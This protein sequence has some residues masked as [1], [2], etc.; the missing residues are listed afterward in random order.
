MSL[1]LAQLQAFKAVINAEPTLV[2][3]RGAGN[4]G[5]IAAFYNGNA[6]SGTIWRPAITAKE[7]NTAIVWAEFIL[8]TAVVQN[9]YFALLQAGVI[10]ATSSNVRAGFSTIFVAAPTSLANL[11]AL[12]QRVPTVFEAL[13]TTNSVCSLFGYTVS[14]A[15]V[16]S[17]LGS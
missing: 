16:V 15:D 11:T 14:V 13:F 6:S 12:A 10:D 8:L 5:A 1:T 2:A 7:L 9:G 3:A 4:H 17:A